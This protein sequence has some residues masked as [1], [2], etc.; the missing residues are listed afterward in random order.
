MYL[1]RYEIFRSYVG[2]G[3]KIN[4]I[5]FLNWEPG[6]VLTDDEHQNAISLKNW[7]PDFLHVKKT[8]HIPA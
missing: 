7:I 2:K 4:F 6:R 5:F 1:V 8:M 3:G